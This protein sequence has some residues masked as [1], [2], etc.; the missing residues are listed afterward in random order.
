MCFFQTDNINE[1]ISPL[2]RMQEGMQHFFGFV[3]I[4]IQVKQVIET[5]LTHKKLIIIF[6][7]ISSVPST[8]YSPE[9]LRNSIKSTILKSQRFWMDLI[10]LLL[11]TILHLPKH[12]PK[13]NSKWIINI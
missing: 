6:F 3:K 10:A 12:H 8:N 7:Y 9:M 5:L 1:T 2:K 11:P 4:E 13:Q